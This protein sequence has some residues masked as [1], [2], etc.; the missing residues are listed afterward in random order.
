VAIGTGISAPIEGV[1]ALAGKLKRIPT[2]IAKLMP[3][4]DEAKRADE[5]ARSRNVPIA[6]E[7][8]VQNNVIRSTARAVDAMDPTNFR[9]KSLERMEDVFKR[10][11]VDPF[12]E[13]DDPI[14]EMGEAFKRDYKAVNDKKR[15]LY[16]NA[17]DEMN[18]LGP[19]PM[20]RFR[21]DITQM[22]DEQQRVLGE[23]SKEVRTLRQWLD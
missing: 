18:P 1:S 16:R 17:W 20:D 12:T 3:M 22:I 7:D 9:N 5:F 23:G 19:V 15:E 6:G 10:E 11:V 2:A 8:L 13:F 21:D 14:F 4:S